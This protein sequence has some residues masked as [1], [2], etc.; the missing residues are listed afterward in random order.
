M[1]LPCEN[2]KNIHA[3]SNDPG[4]ICSPKIQRRISL[5]DRQTDTLLKLVKLN[6]HILRSCHGNTT[7]FM[8]KKIL[9]YVKE[10]LQMKFIVLQKTARKKQPIRTK[11]EVPPR[12]DQQ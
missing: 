7:N 3:Y 12:D 2:E 9:T 10:F 5:L 8:C 4:N 6:V 11:T 1:L